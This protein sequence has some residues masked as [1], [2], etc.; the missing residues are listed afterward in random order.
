MFQIG[1]MGEPAHFLLL[2]FGDDFLVFGFVGKKVKVKIADRSVNFCEFISIYGFHLH[3][4]RFK[5]L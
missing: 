2:C 5:I 4:D 1:F 3:F